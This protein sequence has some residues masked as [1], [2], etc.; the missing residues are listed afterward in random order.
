MDRV[1][2]TDALL[3]LGPREEPGRVRFLHVPW[4]ELAEGASAAPPG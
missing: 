4:G 1:G 3:D 2:R